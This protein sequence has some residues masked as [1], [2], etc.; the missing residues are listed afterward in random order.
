ME[1][2]IVEFKI[3]ETQNENWNDTLVK[4]RLADPHYSREYA[5][6]F[7]KVTSNPEFN[8][9]FVGKHYLIV[10]TNKDGILVYPTIKREITILG[11][12]INDLTSPY[13]Y[14]G[15]LIRGDNKPIICK[16]TK[17]KNQKSR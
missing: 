5:L 6:L 4:H 2:K 1:N 8:Q 10:Y 13:G 11:H 16:F 9:N 3:F 12:K 7:E 15:P 14:G 17:L